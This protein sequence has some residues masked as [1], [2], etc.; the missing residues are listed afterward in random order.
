MFMHWSLHPHLS[1]FAIRETGLLVCSPGRSKVIMIQHLYGLHTNV[2]SFGL[3]MFL[4]NLICKRMKNLHTSL[5]N[6][7]ITRHARMRTVACYQSLN[8]TAAKRIHSN[9]S[10]GFFLFGWRNPYLTL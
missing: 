3:E 4:P 7:Y 8:T 2:L 10:C 9:V 1:Q 5:C 6:A